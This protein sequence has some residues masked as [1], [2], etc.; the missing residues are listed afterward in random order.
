MFLLGLSV[1]FSACVPNKFASR[2]DGVVIDSRSSMPLPGATLVS[3]IWHEDNAIGAFVVT[4]GKGR[5]SLSNEYGFIK[6]LELDID[7]REIVIS[8]EGYESE[9]IS[10]V[11]RGTERWVSSGKDRL[12]RMDSLRNQLFQIKLQ[13]SNKG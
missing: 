1:L 5:F 7:S 11:H 2:L 6:L 9:E 13:K 3:G 4:D 10:V 12:L 8:K